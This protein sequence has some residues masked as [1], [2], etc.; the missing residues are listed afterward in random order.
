MTPKISAV[1]FRKNISFYL[2]VVKVVVK[3]DDC[4]SRA[5]RYHLTYKNTQLR[6]K[7]I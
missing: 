3:Q 2:G 5:T 1:M 6:G 7:Q 4:E